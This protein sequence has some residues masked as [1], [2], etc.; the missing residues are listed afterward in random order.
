MFSRIRS[1][2]PLFTSRLRVPRL[3][4]ASARRLA[5]AGAAAGAAAAFA[6]SLH[7][8]R[9]SSPLDA[10]GIVAYIGKDEATPYLLEGL[11]ILQNRG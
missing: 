9:T 7:E 5:G 8:A 6:Y 3:A 1:R 11:Q 4:S 10:C 2:L